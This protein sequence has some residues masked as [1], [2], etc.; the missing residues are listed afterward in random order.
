MR[1]V[2]LR[3][4]PGAGRLRVG[5]FLRSET[6]EGERFGPPVD[7]PARL[8]E[9]AACIS[10]CGQAAPGREVQGRWPGGRESTGRC[11]VSHGAWGRSLNSV[12]LFVSLPVGFPELG[13]EN[14]WERVT[15][16][17]VRSRSR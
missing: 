16:G 1:S 8:G 4:S 10:R 13:Q 7:A 11:G 17:F 2:L 15:V 3:Y 9:G 6:W 12:G 5:P 14:G